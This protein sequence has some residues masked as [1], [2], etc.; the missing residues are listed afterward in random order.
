MF[1]IP[2]DLTFEEMC[3]LEAVKRHMLAKLHT[4]RLRFIFLYVIE[5]GNKQRDAA[6]ILGVHETEISRQL[7]YIREQLGEFKEGY[8]L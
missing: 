1:E 2:K 7:R 3:I 4:D 8:T 6:S 5:M